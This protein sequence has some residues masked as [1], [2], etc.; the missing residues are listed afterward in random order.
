MAH[1]SVGQLFPDA[2]LDVGG[3]RRAVGCGGGVQVRRAEGLR[4]GGAGKRENSKEGKEDPLG[5][6]QDG[7]FKHA[8]ARRGAKKKTRG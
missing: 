1:R 3:Q 5:R 2:E 4:E 6:S 8:P 7:L